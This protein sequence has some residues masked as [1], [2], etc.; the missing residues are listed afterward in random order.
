MIVSISQT[1]IDN[2]KM[3]VVNHPKF[4]TEDSEGNR[5]RYLATEKEDWDILTQINV[6]DLK[7]AVN[8]YIQDHEGQDNSAMI[9]LN[10]ELNGFRKAMVYA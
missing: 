2:L 7:E 4:E 10:N 3:A 9:T 5:F 8:K 1:E 6:T